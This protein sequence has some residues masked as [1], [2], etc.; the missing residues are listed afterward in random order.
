VRLFAPG[1]FEGLAAIG[2]FGHDLE[3]RLMREQ[4]A[5]TAPD[6]G[7]VVREKNPDSR[8]GLSYPLD[9]N[10]SRPAAPEGILQTEEPVCRLAPPDWRKHPPIVGL[11]G[12]AAAD[13]IEL[14]TPIRRI[15]SNCR[16]Y[17]FSF[18]S[19]LPGT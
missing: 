10:Y 18:R 16:I 13:T 7:V 6:N 5:Q 11:C 1:Q 19:A 2:G 4:G 15:S 8:H 3:R 17:A 14:T 9:P 12:A